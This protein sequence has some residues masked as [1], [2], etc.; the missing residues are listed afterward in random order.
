MTGSGRPIARETPRAGVDQ[1]SVEGPGAKQPSVEARFV[2]PTSRPPTSYQRDSIRPRTRSAS[3]PRTPSPPQVILRVK[4]ADLHRGSAKT[5]GLAALG[6]SARPPLL[7]SLTEVE[8]GE[9]PVLLDVQ[10]NDALESQLQA[11]KQQGV[12][13]VRSEPTLLTASG[14]P[15]RF[16]T[17]A[18]SADFVAGP[19]VQPSAGADASRTD[20]TLL[21]LVADQGDILL[22][23]TC[24]SS[25]PYFAADAGATPPSR[26]RQMKVR[27]RPGQT[28]AVTGLGLEPS[29]DEPGER[30]NTITRVLGLAKPKGKGPEMVML[31]TPELVGA[32]PAAS[33]ATL[34]G[35]AASVPARSRAWDRSPEAHDVVRPP[36]RREVAEPGA[37]TETSP[38]NPFVRLWRTAKRKLPLGKSSEIR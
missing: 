23:V 14:R 20:V 9:G 5:W 25:V 2:S 1:P 13:R 15:T 33:A 28:L 26:R 11:L 34:A 37:P 6:L 8:P 27:M 16:A 31:V 17:G 4:V 21:P 12:L 19:D 32:P 10:G 38:S 35:R 30:P 18:G 3:T 7:R 24:T 36:Q 22:E 29:R